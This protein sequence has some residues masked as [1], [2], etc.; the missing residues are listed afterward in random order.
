MH[1]NLVLTALPGVEVL[2]TFGLITD[3]C[4]V[5][6]NAVSKGLQQRARFYKQQI[7]QS[8]FMY[9]YSSEITVDKSQLL[10]N[11]THILLNEWKMMMQN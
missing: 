6:I 2:K 4:N 1:G 11:N 8:I 9:I 3:W 10:Y 5:S 7:K